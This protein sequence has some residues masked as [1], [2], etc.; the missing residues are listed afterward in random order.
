MPAAGRIRITTSKSTP[1]IPSRGRETVALSFIVSR[2]A[3]EPGFRLDRQESGGR[4]IRYTLHSYATDQPEGERY[5][6]S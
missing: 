5:G 3:R 1:I 2:P 4:T 6:N